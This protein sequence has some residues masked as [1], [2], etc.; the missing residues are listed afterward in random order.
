MLKIYHFTV[1][2]YYHT[3]HASGQNRSWP[4]PTLNFLTPTSFGKFTC[5][6][7]WKSFSWELSHTLI[8]S[9][10]CFLS[11]VYFT[12]DSLYNFPVEIV[13]N[14]CF[15]KLISSSSRFYPTLEQ[16]DYLFSSANIFNFKFFSS[17]QIVAE[18]SRPFHRLELWN[19]WLKTTLLT[20]ELLF[21]LPIVLYDWDDVMKTDHSYQ[22]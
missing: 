6:A 18:R 4:Q 19:I 8:S 5:C 9:S 2:G 11:S 17:G 10:V 1:T 14:Y 21:Q 13:K 16:S 22:M 3:T 20:I 15:A 7:N 12:P